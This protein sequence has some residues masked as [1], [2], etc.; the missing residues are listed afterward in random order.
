MKKHKYT[1]LQNLS[2]LLI[3]L[4]ILITIFFLII[5]IGFIFAKGARVLSWEFLT[6]PPK[7]AMTAGGVAPAIIGTFYL[8]MTAIIFALPLGLACAIYL[9]EFSPKSFVVN[10]IR[11]SINNL[12]GV[13]SIIFG[14]FGLAIFVKQL[15]FGVSILSGGLTLAIMV[16]PGIISATNESLLAVPQSLREASLSVGA[17]QWQTI[18]KV[19][20]PTALPGILTGV[21]LSIG[22]AAG[23][24]AP[25][26]FTAAVFYTKNYPTS[27]FSEVM[28]LPYHIYALMTE[29]TFPQQQTQIAYGCAVILLFLVLAIS[30]IAIYIRNK[31]GKRYVY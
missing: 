10:I 27:I 21:I 29:G 7:E 2:F 17:T 18:K 30:I 8:T 19:V 20:L 24:T 16:L 14:L 26:L 5:T 4:C 15:G 25:I 1:L 6:K 11:M 12:A 13:P 28:A 3:F 9:S 23:E 31:Y 22:R